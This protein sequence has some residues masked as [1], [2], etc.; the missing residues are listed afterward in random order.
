MDQIACR[1]KGVAQLKK[2]KL[3]ILKNL[4]FY[5]RVHKCSPIESVLNRMNL[6]HML[7]SYLLQTRSSIN[8]HF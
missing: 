6:L 8:H 7:A 3:G 5:C 4:K 2:K 1:Q